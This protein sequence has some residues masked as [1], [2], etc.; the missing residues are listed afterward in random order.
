MQNKTLS[1]KNLFRELKFE[2]NYESF[3]EFYDTN[4]KEIYRS[5]ID[6]FSEFKKTRK[7]ILTLKI[8]AQIM[9]LDWDTDF[10]FRKE[11]SIVLQ[12]DLMPFF[13]DNEDYETCSE[14]LNLHKELTCY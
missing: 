1:T 14:I 11:E 10:N 12:R 3:S 2:K 5:I 4:K 7:R 6:L 8:S 9:G 13:E